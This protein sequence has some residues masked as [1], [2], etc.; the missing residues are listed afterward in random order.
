MS[1]TD[2][3]MD[4]FRDMT[5]KV[6]EAEILPHYED[7]EKQ[8]F[9]D[10]EA[11]NRLGESGLLGTDLPEEYGGSDVPPAVTFMII[12]ELG[13]AN[14]NGL[15]GGFNI[16]SNIVTPYVHRLGTDEQRQKWLPKMVS[17]EVISAIAMTEPGAGSDLANIRTSAVKDGD[18]WVING[19]KIFITNGYHA[20]LVIVAAK[21]D[22]DAG[23]K[24]IS[25]FLVDTKTEGYSVGGLIHKIGQKAGDTAELG[26]NDVRVPADC[27][28]GQI[29]RGFIHMMEELPRERMGVAA[30]AIGSVDGT[31]DVTAEYVRERKAFGK[32][33]SDFQN[34]R[35]TLAELK[36]KQE[37]ARSYYNHCA[38]AYSRDEMT[39]EMASILKLTTSE[40]Q[41]EAADKC[42]QL[43]G[44]YGYTT[45]YPISR[46]YVDARVQ[47]IYAG[48]SEIMKEVISRGMLGR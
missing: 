2:E 3:D 6:I 36:A 13:R 17:G 25:L 23:A 46:F 28:L 7:W 18:E 47:T 10:R 15:A 26:F 21:T 24:G 44:G 38:D 33:V 30:Q 9:I 31:L 4:M 8:G 45:E 5:R 1:F 19:S 43:H 16:H 34:T 37:L 20:D 27:L 12:E 42:L 40:L 22:K 48:T 32:A 35:F 39:T 29:N 11:W 41:C 14:C